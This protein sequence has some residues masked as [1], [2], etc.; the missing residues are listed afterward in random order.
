MAEMSVVSLFYLM[1][2]VKILS[3]E[4]SM[5]SFV[6]LFCLFVCLFACL[7]VLCHIIRIRSTCLLRQVYGAS[8]G[9]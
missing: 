5:K 7:F 6:F 3:W 8:E 4:L 9:P 1:I 2:K